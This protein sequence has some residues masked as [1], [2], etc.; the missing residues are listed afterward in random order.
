[1]ASKREVFENK[2]TG[3]SPEFDSSVGPSS[4]SCKDCEMHYY[5]KVWLKLSMQTEGAVMSA[6]KRA[7]RKYVKHM[8][9]AQDRLY[10]SLDD[11]LR[12]KLQQENNEFSLAID[13]WGAHVAKREVGLKDF[14]MCFVEINHKLSCSKELK[15]TAYSLWIIHAAKYNS[16][17][18]VQPA[19]FLENYSNFSLPN[20]CK[21]LTGYRYLPMDDIHSITKQTRSKCEAH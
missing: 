14:R 20:S 10:N 8:P 5:T 7:P 3:S 19:L 1:M 4:S 2:P 21:I 17:S 13:R 16:N 9:K 15:K 6:Y 11:K 18:L 12:H